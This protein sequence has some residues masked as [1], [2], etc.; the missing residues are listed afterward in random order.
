M[1]KTASL[2]CCKVSFS[3]LS[4][5]KYICRKNDGEGQGASSVERQRSQDSVQSQ[6]LQDSAASS[7]RSL[8]SSPSKSGSGEGAEIKP[9]EHGVAKE[10]TKK[11]TT[12]AERRALQVCVCV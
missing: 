8:F 1:K 9:K 3:L 11:T 12:K 5:F 7:K 2:V 10:T 6:Q 4:L